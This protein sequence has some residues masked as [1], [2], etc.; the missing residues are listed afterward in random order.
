MEEAGKVWKH[1]V[2]V[3]LYSVI[4]ATLTDVLILSKS[5]KLILQ[6]IIPHAWLLWQHSIRGYIIRTADMY[7]DIKLG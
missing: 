3:V 5:Y 4:T 2:S 7:S 1:A 6:D